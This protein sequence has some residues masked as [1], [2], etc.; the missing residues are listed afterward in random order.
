MKAN[1]PAFKAALTA[2]VCNA[3]GGPC[4]YTGAGLA[5]DALKGANFKEADL[6]ALVEDLQL[7]L[8]KNQVP[9]PLR[10]KLLAV[11]APLRS[12]VDYK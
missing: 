8:D 6:N 5:D 7:A 4:T 12:Q 3:V 11:P 2:Q 10:N 9:I 1:I